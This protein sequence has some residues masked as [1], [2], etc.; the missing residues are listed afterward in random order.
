MSISALQDQILKLKLQ[1]MSLMDPSLLH[2]PWSSPLLH[3]TLEQHSKVR[4]APPYEDSVRILD[5][6]PPQEEYC[7]WSLETKPFDK[8]P[9]N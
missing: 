4:A 2:A 6:F 5:M 7:P 8:T 3:P 1:D 9:G